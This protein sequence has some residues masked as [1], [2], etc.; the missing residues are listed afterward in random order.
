MMHLLANHGPDT[1][2][3]VTD[4]PCPCLAS[5]HPEL[6]ATIHHRYDRKD[7]YSSAYDTIMTLSYR[8]KARGYEFSPHEVW[9]TRWSLHRLEMAGDLDPENFHHDFLDLDA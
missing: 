3:H 9:I 8:L 4:G 2:E 6:G 5:L 1:H 7:V